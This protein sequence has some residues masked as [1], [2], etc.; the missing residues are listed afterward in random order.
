MADT[1]DGAPEPPEPGDAPNS[2]DGGAAGPRPG[3]VRFSLCRWA[4]DPRTTWTARRLAFEAGPGMD[5]D[6]GWT[7]ARIARHPDERAQ[8]LRRLHAPKE[9]YGH[10]FELGR[11]V[12]GRLLVRDPARP[13]SARNISMCVCRAAA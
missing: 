11:F 1:K 6:S 5:A 8:L 3:P 7:T 12:V 13:A 2:P 10:R 4:L 9:R